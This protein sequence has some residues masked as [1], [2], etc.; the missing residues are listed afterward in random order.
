[1]VRVNIKLDSVKINNVEMYILSELSGC[2]IL[3][4]R[5]VTEGLDLMY[6]RIGENLMFEYAK[7]VE[8]ACNI[9]DELRLDFDT[10]SHY[11][12]IVSPLTKLLKKN[13]PWVWKTEHDRAFMT[14][15][16][17]LISD[18][19]LMLF[20]L[21]K[22]CVLYTDASR[23]GI[24]GILM[25]VSDS[26][27]K[28]IHYYSRQTT[29]DE[30][31]RFALNKKE[32]IP[33]IARW[34]LATQEFSY[35]IIHREG[36]RIQHVDALSRN[37][38][39]SGSKSEAEIIMP[40]P[41]A[42][43]LFSVQLQDSR[44][45]DIKKSLESGDAHKYKDIFNKCELLGIAHDEVERES[46]CQSST[47]HNI[48]N[49]D[50]DDEISVG[51]NRSEASTPRKRRFGFEN[52]PD[53][54]QKKIDTED[55]ERSSPMEYNLNRLQN[56]S[57]N[58]PFKEEEN[59]YDRTEESM[60][61]YDNGLFHLYRTERDGNKDEAKESTFGMAG[62]LSEGIYGRSMDLSK[63]SFQS[64]LLAG[65]ASVMAGSSQRESQEAADRQQPKSATPTTGR[66][67]RRRRTAFT[68]AQLAYLE[69]K[70]RCQKY[71]SVADRGDVA[72]A[73]S[74]SET[75]VKTWYQNRRTKWKRQN[76]LRLEQLRAQAASGERELSAHALPLACALL[77]PYPAYMHC[78]L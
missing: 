4:G 10:D 39:Q 7:N 6:S 66:K 25:Q 59:E 30:K 24:A 45:A 65:F 69:R 58:S 56:S 36:Y 60:K 29:D 46:R 51:D 18:N 61:L 64:Q 55:N 77:P 20:D 72:D 8:S 3:I 33:R 73:L 63:S 74:L 12:E 26:V 53:F 32:I 9:M 17:A 75:Q 47:S 41:E 71:L 28:P 44:I 11:D 15:K 43:W 70:F 49:S 2:D 1:M 50:I 54:Y 38:L 34:V 76:Q 67:P 22:E 16:D 62:G 35:D 14:L 27:K 19:I 5:N 48:E 68:H 40:I 52:E 31:I 37:P 78:H 23:D 13:V 21:T 57:Y 42:D